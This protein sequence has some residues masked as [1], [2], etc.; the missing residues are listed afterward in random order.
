MSSF[1]SV[2]F[3]ILRSFQRFCH[4]KFNGGCNKRN[5]PNDLYCVA[6][7]IDQLFYR[8][9]NSKRRRK[10]TSC[11]ADKNCVVVGSV[12]E[13]EQILKAASSSANA[14]DTLVIG[15]D[16]LTGA[17]GSQTVIPAEDA[18]GTEA[19][20]ASGVPTKQAPVAAAAANC[21]KVEDTVKL[22][23]TGCSDDY[24]DCSMEVTNF[25]EAEDSGESGK[26]SQR[27]IDDEHNEDDDE[28]DDDK[29]DDDDA[30]DSVGFLMSDCR[31]NEKAVIRIAKASIFYLL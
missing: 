24:Q 22:N 2:R 23:S 29:D 16:W 8:V 14:P 3:C 30:D 18:T 31:I 13:S 10:T 26:T 1:P 17:F 15:N 21:N 4:Q 7:R 9:V 20:A 12:P 25:T 5:R 19:G 6:R 11:S 27:E 28:D